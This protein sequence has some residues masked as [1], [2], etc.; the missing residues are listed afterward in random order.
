MPKFLWCHVI[1]DEMRNAKICL[2]KRHSR[3]NVEMLL[4]SMSMSSNALTKLFI[5]KDVAFDH[6]TIKCINKIVCDCVENAAFD[7]NI[8]KCIDDFVWWCR[9]WCWQICLMK[10][11]KQITRFLLQFFKQMTSWLLNFSNK[12]KMKHINFHHQFL[13]LKRRF[14]DFEI[15]ISYIIAYQFHQSMWRYW[16]AKLMIRN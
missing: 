1:R 9:K 8:I 5:V 15:N 16:N 6:D 7:V 13:V 10:F 4:H 2:I 3:W 12:W 11:F 14:D